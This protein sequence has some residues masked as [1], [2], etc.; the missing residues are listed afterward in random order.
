MKIVFDFAAERIAIEGNE[1]ELVELLKVV[2]E[3]A[4][5]LSNISISTGKSGNRHVASGGGTAETQSRPPEKPSNGAVFTGQTLKQFARSLCLSNIAEKIAAIA[6]YVK[7]F[8][9][10]PTFAPKEM[11]AWFN[12]CGFEIPTQMATA[13]FNAGKHQRVVEN[14]G[15]GS[16]Q[17]T[18]AGENL[19]I[20]K[21]NQA[22]AEGK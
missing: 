1:P 14:N 18:R 3:L 5:S 2:R 20:G 16:W 11:V 6:Y 9:E 15:H 12:T 8:E 4:P 19:V 13:I 10:K 22:D 7:H 21:Q 17:L